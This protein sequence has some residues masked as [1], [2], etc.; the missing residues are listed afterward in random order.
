MEM[1]S[2]VNSPMPSIGQASL[3]NYNMYKQSTPSYSWYL[4]APLNFVP[5]TGIYPGYQSASQYSALE[6]W[7]FDPKAGV[8]SDIAGLQASK[9]NVPAGFNQT[10]ALTPVGALLVQ[11]PQTSYMSDA[12]IGSYCF[13]NLKHAEPLSH[14]GIDTRAIAG[15][16]I[17]LDFTC[18]PI[19]SFAVVFHIRFT[20]TIVLAE[21][22]VSIVG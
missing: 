19:E 15:G 10:G 9:I 12:Y 20:R 21:N 4:G 17:Q 6:S 5:S 14:D 1:L 8:F 2:A 22:G 13:D 18:E 3:I 7:R 16:M 11:D